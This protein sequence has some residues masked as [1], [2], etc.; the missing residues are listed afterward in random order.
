MDFLTFE[1]IR[2]PGIHVL[3]DAIQTAPSMPKSG[4]MANQHGKVAAAVVLAGQP[5]N[6]VPVPNDT[7]YSF[8]DDRE[9]VHVASVHS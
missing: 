4:H 6:P 1:S 2:A 7:S 9:A 3:G 5:P 8:I